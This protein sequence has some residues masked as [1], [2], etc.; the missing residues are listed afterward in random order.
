MHALRVSPRA[1]AP[2]LLVVAVVV[3]YA[4]SLGG[5]LNWDDPW[6]IEQNPVLEARLTE[7]LRRIWTDFGLDNRLAL[8]AEFLP[9]RDMSMWLDVQLFGRAPQAM[10]LMQL[11]LYVIAVLFFRAALLRMMPQR[12]AAEAAAWV[13]ALHP[14]HA[15]SVAWLAGRKDVLALL[16]VGAALYAYAAAKPRA[17]LVT[18]LLAAACLSKSMSVAALGLLV[19]VDV[20]QRRRVHWP[21]HVLAAVVLAALFVVHVAVGRIVG[22]TTEPLGGTRWSAAAAMGVVWL[23]YGIELVWPAGLSIVQDPPP[24]QW[25]VLA[26]L[27]WAALAGWGAAAVVP[28]LAP[29]K[30]RLKLQRWRDASPL[31]LVSWLW[32]WVPLVPVSQILFPLQNFM[33]DRYL[34]L[35][36]M[37]PALGLGWLVHKQAKWGSAVGVTA[38]L[39]LSALTVER[40][41]L[42]GDS[43]RVFADATAKTQRSTMAPY[44]LGQA[45][46]QAGDELR[47]M[48]AYELAIQRDTSATEAAR[49][50]VNNLAKLC[51]RRGLLPQAERALRLGHGRWPDDAKVL[52]NL[53]EVLALQQR[54]PE[55][56]RLFEQLVRRFPTY[57]WGVQRYQQRYGPLPADRHPIDFPAQE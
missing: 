41:Y 35:S 30:R 3:C 20:L 21:T 2:L 56:R 7:A 10:R 24:A 38:L 16:F 54:E 34:F 9:L 53:A 27:G 50:A 11:G 4:P 17:W 43:V 49:R 47:A 52:G 31:L 39:A 33:A 51:A 57:A 12:W 18:L 48:Q 25:S 8:G 42:F 36:V 28:H 40:A 37:A 55:A 45:Y 22:M 32:F 1:L 46:E 14:L 13:F 26:V 15:E 19:T 5:Y 23:R 6:L 44:Q 29:L